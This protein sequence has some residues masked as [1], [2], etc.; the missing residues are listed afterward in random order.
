MA[1][2]SEFSRQLADEMLVEQVRRTFHSMSL[3]ESLK[4]TAKGDPKNLVGKVVTF[5]RY[6]RLSPP[7]TPPSPCQCLGCQTLRETILPKIQWVLAK[8]TEEERDALYSAVFPAWDEDE[9]ESEE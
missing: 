8:G 4:V 7:T 5:T 2:S 6:E 1:F 9:E 3:W